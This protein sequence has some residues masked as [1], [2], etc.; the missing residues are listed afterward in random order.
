MS[1]WFKKEDILYFHLA[2]VMKNAGHIEPG[3][4]ACWNQH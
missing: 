4:K 1:L 2:I 3:K